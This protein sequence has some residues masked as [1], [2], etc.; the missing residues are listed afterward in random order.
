MPTDNEGESATT[1]VEKSSPERS[2]VT[3]IDAED[4][5]KTAIK[6]Q[7]DVLK[8][9]DT[10]PV[11][12]RI[13]DNR[14]KIK[15]YMT[16]FINIVAR[17]EVVLSMTLDK[18]HKQTVLLDETLE[19]FQHK[20]SEPPTISNAIMTK[21]PRLKSRYRSRRREEGIVTLIYPKDEG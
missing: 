21:Q 12:N 9:L 16:D 15:E 4:F 14:D 1:F 6:T 3:G 18:L 8:F 13:K 10:M 20:S 19:R 2:P 11:K 5:L 7:T 17:Q